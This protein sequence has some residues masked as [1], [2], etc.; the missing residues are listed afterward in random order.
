MQE[1]WIGK[2][3]AS[4]SAFPYELDGESKLLRVFTTRADTIMGVTFMRDRRRAS[5]RDPAWRRRPALAAFIEE[6]KRG[7][8]PRPT[9]RRWK[10]RAWPPAFPSRIR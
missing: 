1:N 9:S 6:C 5:A 8:V 4:T 10:R 2:S 3:V 7:G